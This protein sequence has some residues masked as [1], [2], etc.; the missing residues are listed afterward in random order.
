[1]QFVQP[2]GNKR[3]NI[4]IIQEKT[5]MKEAISILCAICLLAG[6]LCFLTTTDT[7]A[8]P[9]NLE[10]PVYAAVMNPPKPDVPIQ[11]VQCPGGNCA[12]GQCSLLQR[13]TVTRERRVE[14]NI[15]SES[16]VSSERSARRP[17]LAAVARPLLRAATIPLRPL[18]RLRR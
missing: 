2:L 11:T 15:K 17:R 6:G 16:T 13:Q 12:N 4:F 3:F 5:K 18:C 8:T 9:L 1:L 10:V 14:K 7:Q